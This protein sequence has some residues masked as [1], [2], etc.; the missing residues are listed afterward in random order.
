[1]GSFAKFRDESLASYASELGAEF[2]SGRSLGER[3]TMGQYMT[4]LEIAR[5]M[6][7]RMADSLDQEVIR[8]L[9]PAAGCGVLVAALVDALIQ[10]KCRPS[11][12]HIVLFEL[13]SS[14]M[15]VLGKVRLRIRQKLKT[16]GIKSS[17]QIENDD[18]LLSSL[19]TE[20]KAQ[21]DLIISNPPYFK[22]PASD[23]RAQAHKSV[24]YGQPNIYGLFMS[25]SA[26]LLSAKGCW[27]FITPRSWTNGLYFKGIRKNLFA[28]LDVSA[29]HVF[30]SRKDP[31]KGEILQEAMITW[32]FAKQNVVSTVAVSKS[33]GVHDLHAPVVHQLDF[34]DFVNRANDYSVQIQ[35]VST[36][37]DCGLTDTLASLGLKVSTGPVI[38]FR[39]KELLHQT[40]SL[41][42]VPLFWMQHV[43]RGKVRWPLQKK[44]EHIDYNSASLW[45]LVKNQNL[46]ILRRFSP[47]ED[48][49]R[50]T[51][52]AYLSD[53]P[54]EY[55]GIENHLNY[56]YGIGS[57]L[58]E[59]EAKGLCAYLNSLPVEEYF[60]DV[61]GSTQ[62]NARELNTLVFPS[63][64]RLAEMGRLVQDSMGLDQID[65]IV[66]DVIQS[67]PSV[68]RKSA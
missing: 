53:I 37:K 24:L 68:K 12:I 64:K 45:M 61:A 41:H 11:E 55:L 67:N 19:A 31:F 32:A 14:L 44:H 27:C 65:R 5:L 50:V 6:A 49:R 60:R 39:N 3:K 21:F 8:I 57:S 46:V 13:D 62:I 18:F 26:D 17:V 23:S 54:T 36:F 29:I 4:P 20:K 63:R 30:E 52:A 34:N 2:S 7:G 25:V 56:I 42:T 59:Y 66:L 38:P 9:E 51:A 10:G 35:A 33:V 16:A 58:T 28:K 43:S 47:K 15:P 22:I 48:V 40:G 1:M